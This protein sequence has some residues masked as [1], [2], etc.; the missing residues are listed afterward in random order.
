VGCGCLLSVAP[1]A[2]QIPDPSNSVVPACLNVAP[3]GTLPVDVHVADESGVPVANASVT[4]EFTC[5]NLAACGSESFCCSTFPIRYCESTDGSGNATFNPAMGGHCC[6]DEA[7]DVSASVHAS[8]PDVAHPNGVRLVC[9]KTYEHVGSPDGTG[10]L[11]VNLEDYVLLEE[12]WVSTTYPCLDLAGCDGF[13]WFADF[14]V[15]SDHFLT[16]CE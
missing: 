8:V 4:L 10:D 11:V 3:N 5:G 6:G 9:L 13:V 12:N 15:F 7:C 2:A 16:Q 14:Y 1:A